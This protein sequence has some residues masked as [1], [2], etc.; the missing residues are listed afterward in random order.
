MCGEHCEECN[1]FI[2]LRPVDFGIVIGTRI[3]DSLPLRAKTV[4][5]TTRCVK[6]DDPDYFSPIVS[7]REPLTAAVVR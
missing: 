6:P 1:K 3:C 5:G 4:L 7:V 2:N